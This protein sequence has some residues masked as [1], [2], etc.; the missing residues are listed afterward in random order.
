MSFRSL[1]LRA[2]LLLIGLL[3]TLFPILALV[4]VVFATSTEDEALYDPGGAGVPDTEVLE[5]DTIDGVPVA[6]LIAAFVLTVMAAAGTWWWSG[7]AVRPM[8][9]ITRT[10][11][12]IQLGSLD[13][14]LGLQ[15]EAAEVQALGDSFDAML[16][17]LQTASHTQHRLIEDASH[18]LRTP[19]AALAVNNEVM[20][21]HPDP[22]I[23]DY[24]ETIQRS[25]ALVQRLQTTIDDLLASARRRN[26]E[27][28][29][30]DNDLVQIVLRVAENHRLVAPDQR[31][32]VSCPAQLQLGIDGPS[33][34][35][36]L[37]NLV[38][39]AARF[40][41]AD[42]PIEIRVMD[43]QIPSVSVTDHGPG[44]D[45]SVRPHLF[46]R[47]ARG[48]DGAGSGIGLAIVK[49]VAE[50]LGSVEVESPLDGS[51]VGT[52]FTM[53]FRT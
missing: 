27:T 3:A 46:D 12:E 50:A 4:T 32:N 43:G 52:R 17:R 33:V 9:D 13:R 35:R 15:D 44:I 8:R 51:D 37:T 47:Y 5:T 53:R 1:S 40:S 22:T 24:R 38:Q 48:Q 41:P 10:A 21:S 45:P 26:Q 25:D 19:L 14:R 31:I 2:Q 29:Q 34:E 39:N 18:E 7:R 16:D 11:N 6:V 36:A 20:L 28:Q 42:K 30:V 23:E 49:H